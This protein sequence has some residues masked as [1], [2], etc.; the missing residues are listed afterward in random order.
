MSLNVLE[1][2][3]IKLLPAAGLYP[4]EKLHDRWAARVAAAG[5]LGPEPCLRRN[6]LGC[7]KKAPPLTL[8]RQGRGILFFTPELRGQCAGAQQETR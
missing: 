6:S 5:L 8:W 3:L 7:P 2:L 1:R 4:L